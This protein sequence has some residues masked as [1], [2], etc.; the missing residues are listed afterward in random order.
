MHPLLLLPG[1]VPVRRRPHQ[2]APARPSF[3]GG[4]LFVTVDFEYKNKAKK[5][6]TE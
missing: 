4:C 1:A 2:N 3:A 6:V 5:K